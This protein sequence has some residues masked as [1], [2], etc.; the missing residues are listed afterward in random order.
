[1]NE[2]IRRAGAA[3]M[4][5]MNGESD[6]GEEED[7]EGAYDPDQL[8]QLRQLK[9]MAEA[10]RQGRKGFFGPVDGQEDDPDYGDEDGHEEDEEDE[11]EEDD[12]AELDEAAKMMLMMEEQEKMYIQQQRLEREYL[13]AAAANGS[14]VGNGASMPTA[15]QLK[16]LQNH[17][18]ELEDELVDEKMIANGDDEDDLILAGAAGAA[19]TE[20]AYKKMVMG[21]SGYSPTAG[22]GHSQSQIDVKTWIEWYLIQEDHDFMVEV[23]KSFVTDK[24]NLIKI[25]ELCGLPGKPLDKKRFKN[26]IRL[27]ISSKVPSEEEL[28]V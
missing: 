18:D 19:P 3:G 11:D 8:A 26:A 21:E 4:L 20:S 12:D 13:K 16:M 1:M 28:Q 5:G 24:F 23:D 27:I 22:N 15:A 14:I 2:L 17:M 9:L 7:D 25:R 10:M 6:Y